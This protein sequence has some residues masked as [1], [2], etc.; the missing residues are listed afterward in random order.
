MRRNFAQV[1]E[2]GRIDLRNEYS[3]FYRIF[4]GNGSKN[5]IPLKEIVSE[6]FLSL[7]FRGFC[8]S[9]DEFNIMHGFLFEKQP[10]NFNEDY[11][12]NFMEYIYNMIIYIRPQDVF[13]DRSKRFCLEQIRK[14]LDSIGYVT[15]NEKEF[16]IFVPRDNC[17]IAVAES[18]LVPDNLSY[19]VLEYNHHSL[20]GNIEAKRDILVKLASILEAYDKKLNEINST[21]K[22]DLF[23]LIN[24]CNIRHN[25]ID[26]SSKQYK[27]Y[28]AEMSEAE[29]ECT[30]DEIYQMCLLAFMQLEHADRREWLK[31]LKGNIDGSQSKI[32]N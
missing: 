26:K 13:F 7:H 12:I 20:K 10:K 23:Q 31:E 3:K 5:D 17:A 4:Y 18:E 11:L 21:Y 30:Y 19:K 22:S 28:I 32:A 1:L 8:L 16:T 29:L 27:K 25:N 6:C 9:L 2:E 24:S 15:A 14:V